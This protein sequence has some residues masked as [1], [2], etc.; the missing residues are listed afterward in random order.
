MAVLAAA[1]GDPCTIHVAGLN[2][3]AAIIAAA[4]ERDRGSRIAQEREQ[5]LALDVEAVRRAAD[6]G[7]PEEAELADGEPEELGCSEAGPSRAGRWRT[8]HHA[9]GSAG[10]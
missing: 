4:H 6:L 7:R 1:T 2:V 3:H 8:F 10:V 5:A 9:K